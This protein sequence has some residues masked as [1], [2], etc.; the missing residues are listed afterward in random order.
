MVTANCSYHFILPFSACSS[1]L[2][3]LLVPMFIRECRLPWR[4]RRPYLA[5]TSAAPNPALMTAVTPSVP[6]HQDP[7]PFLLHNLVCI[8]QRNKEGIIFPSLQ[9]TKQR[10]R[11]VK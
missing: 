6:H 3:C 11:E 5:R 10:P 8:Q 1:P 4:T 9:M 7:K 2:R